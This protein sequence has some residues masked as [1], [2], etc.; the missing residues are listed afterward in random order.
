MDEPWDLDPDDEEEM[1]AEM[2]AQQEA[3]AEEFEA[4]E[5]AAATKKRPLQAAAPRGAPVPRGPPKPAPKPAGPSPSYAGPPLPK[6][7]NVYES[8]STCFK[9]GLVGHW[10]RDCKENAA[11]AAPAA[12][13]P[14]PAPPVSHDL[15]DEDYDAEPAAAPGEPPA[16]DCACGAGQ[17]AVRTSQSAAVLSRTSFCWVWHS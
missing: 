13:K 5:A 7:P 12:K 11:P 14:R 6:A 10:A 17:C 1:M 16:L 4:A 3:A 2:A 15:R 9:C 8:T